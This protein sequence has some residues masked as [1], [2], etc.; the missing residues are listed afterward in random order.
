M[1]VVRVI[2]CGLLGLST[3]AGCRSAPR[4]P[5]PLAAPRY[6]PSA[7]PSAPSAPVPRAARATPSG[8]R[9]LQFEPAAPP[10]RGRTA[11]VGMSSAEARGGAPA[12][13]SGRVVDAQ[14][15]PQ[16]HAHIVAVMTSGT[17]VESTA[18]A[19]GN[20]RLT[21]LVPGHRYLILASATTASDVLIGR[22]ATT[23]PDSNVVIQLTR[24]AAGVRGNATTTAPPPPPRMSRSDSHDTRHKQN[25]A[26][27]I[28]DNQ[29]DFPWD[30]PAPP[31]HRTP[32]PS[33]AV[34]GQQAGEQTGDTTPLMRPGRKQNSGSSDVDPPQA[35][36]SRQFSKAEPPELRDRKPDARFDP[37]RPLAQP[38]QIAALPKTAELSN[39]PNIARLELEPSRPQSKPPIVAPRVYQ[40]PSCSF[41]GNR[42][43]DFELQGLDQ[44]PVTFSSLNGRLILVDFFGTWCVP[45]MKAV[46]HLIE[47]QKRYGAQGLQ[48]LGIACEQSGSEPGEQIAEVKAVRDRLGIN[49]PVLL[50]EEYG[51]PSDLRQSFGVSAYPT[52]VLLDR[53][54]RVIW[55][56]V[57][58]DPAH[59]A[60]LENLLKTQ[61]A[62]RPAGYNNVGKS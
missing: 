17:K 62:S 36:A 44:Q 28:A 29:P 37:S 6:V 21:G 40:G 27:V 31:V 60:Q 45:C 54:G 13:I 52:L 59:R 11:P 34:R 50:G 10:A 33:Q 43:N 12:G 30:M 8:P 19:N 15:R 47:L 4:P 49:Y 35:L 55:Q 39:P 56:S 25:L 5:N 14:A 58:L 18:D 7:V 9:M 42:L 51:K 16:P 41:D 26:E 61:L 20:F 46:P 2:I 38:T 22:A 1:V 23:P 3:L 48:V 53:S 24:S 32:P 57:G